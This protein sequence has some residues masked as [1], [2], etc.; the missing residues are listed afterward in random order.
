MNFP[1]PFPI[2]RAPRGSHRAPLVLIH[3]G[4]GTI[5]SYLKL[6]PLDRA[7]YGIHNKRPGPHGRWEGGLHQMAEE[8]YG[9]IKSIISNGPFILGGQYIPRPPLNR[10]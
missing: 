7:V 2:Q 9:L 1:N 8:Y 4:G 3:D 6:S 5:F 10:G